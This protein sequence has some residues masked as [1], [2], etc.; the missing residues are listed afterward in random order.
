MKGGP[1]VL[2]RAATEGQDLPFGGTDPLPAARAVRRALA[3][4]GR[5]AVDVS[6]LAVASPAP[7]GDDELAR[8][9][10]RALGPHG[11]RVPATG[12]VSHATSADALAE[13]ASAHVASL[14]TATPA[15]EPAGPTRLGIG[16]GIAPDG[17]IVALC[18]ALRIVLPGA[19]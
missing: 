5:R 7:I 16:V 10:R 8:L 12:V 2:G 14:L 11:E 4:A 18:V 6:D 19:G 9:A 13:V 3:D 1:V 15:S 17:T